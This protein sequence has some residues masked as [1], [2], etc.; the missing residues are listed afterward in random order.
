MRTPASE[1]AGQAVR[2]ALG[3]GALCLALFGCTRPP[4]VVSACEEPAS[5]R[6]GIEAAEL[7]PADETIPDGAVVA[8]GRIGVEGAAARTPVS[9][10]LVRYVDEP[11]PGENPYAEQE[12]QL[13]PDGRFGWILP[14]GHY[15]IHAILLSRDSGTGEHA[16]SEEIPVLTEFRVA[17][18]AQVNYLGALTVAL[19]PEL[20]I[21]VEDERARRDVAL[22]TWSSFKDRPIDAQLMRYNPEL[23][24]ANV[25]QRQFCRK[26]SEVCWDVA[27]ATHAIPQMRSTFSAPVC[28]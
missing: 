6:P 20:K 18:D 28:R 11:V 9:V 22:P 19:A 26:W 23:A 10:R 25:G 14:K 24:T 5:V 13:R 8:F 7:T 3:A 4:P 15:S 17:K 2:T 21:T 1:T 16:P 12:L 27:A